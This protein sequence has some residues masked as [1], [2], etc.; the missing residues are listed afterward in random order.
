[1]TVMERKAETRAVTGLWI[2]V[3]LWKQV[4]VAAAQR[5]VKL[6]QA[7]DAGLRWWLKHGKEGA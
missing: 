6:W 3:A 7:V 2:S 5:G 4:Q 1:M